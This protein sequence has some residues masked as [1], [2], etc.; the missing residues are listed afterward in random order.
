MHGKNRR[1]LIP[2]VRRE[3]RDSGKEVERN[4]LSP[5]SYDDALPLFIGGDQLGF[6][7]CSRLRSDEGND[8][9]LFCHAHNL[10]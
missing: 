5:D 7:L 9:R 1:R 4:A 10:G 2:G 8:F 6:L 3:S